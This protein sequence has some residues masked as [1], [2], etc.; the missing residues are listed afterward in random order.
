MVISAMMMVLVQCRSGTRSHRCGH[1]V[2]D[3]WIII[4]DKGRNAGAARRDVVLVEYLPDT[5]TA[6]RECPG[7]IGLR[8]SDLIGAADGDIAFRLGKMTD[9]HPMPPKPDR[10]MHDRF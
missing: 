9:L 2:E 10:P 5:L 7:D 4:P 3:G 8:E 6:E 1:A